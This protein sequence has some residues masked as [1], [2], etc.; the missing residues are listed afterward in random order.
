[1]FGLLSLLSIAATTAW[2]GGR[3]DR[4]VA[5]PATVLDLQQAAAVAA[6]Q[7]VRNGM[8]AGLQDLRQL[9]SGLSVVTNAATFDG[10][11]KAF[12]K[13]YHRYRSVYVLD[14]S[15]RVMAWA[16]MAPHLNHVPAGPERAGMTDAVD[17]DHVAVVVQYAPFLSAGRQAIA[18]AEYD[19]A[20]LRFALDTVKPSAAWVVNAKGEVVASTKGFVAFEHLARGLLRG[21]AA[22][23]YDKPGVSISHGGID[24][25]E[26][27]ASAPVRDGDKTS[28]VP[29][30]GLVTARSINAVVLPQTQARDQ[31]LLVALAL[32][33]VT[34]GVFGWLY[35][36]WLR[37]LRRLVRDADR[38]AQG[39]L[40][41]AV[42][43]RR[44]DEVGLVAG[45]VERIRVGLIRDIAARRQPDHTQLLRTVPT[46][47]D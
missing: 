13:R 28:V 38:I 14:A 18:V 12:A 29:Q 35:L 31:A 24:A 22:A 43:I 47:V 10:Q 2:V 19:L 1:M 34:V 6:A 20:R 7:Q 21:A 26:I 45:A 8:Q 25:G 17:I 11:V 23:S 9:A 32:T 46:E 27:V 3:V 36:M 16:G 39:D 37:P 5:V 41:T 30:W 33:V 42:E 15:R 4:G 40:T 44:H